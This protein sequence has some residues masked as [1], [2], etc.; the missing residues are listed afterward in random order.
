MKD[1]E[2]QEQL[3][4]AQ[5]KVMKLDEEAAGATEAGVSASI[6]TSAA[7]SLPVP[8]AP[9]VFP[10]ASQSRPKEDVVDLT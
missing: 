6:S 5:Q 10:S 3:E 4:E 2:E 1:N 9:S 8:R 7:T